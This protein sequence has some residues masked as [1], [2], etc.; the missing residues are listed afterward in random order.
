MCML[1]YFLPLYVKHFEKEGNCAALEI[2][3]NYLQYFM[4]VPPGGADPEARRVER[5]TRRRKT[6]ERR[7][8][9]TKPPGGDLP[10]A[11]SAGGRIHRLRTFHKDE[12]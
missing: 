2:L 10:A 9:Q 3:S 7:H 8:R 5:E 12:V 1:I 11:P 6:A 4:F